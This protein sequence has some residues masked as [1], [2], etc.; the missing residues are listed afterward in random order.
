MP[1]V[2]QQITDLIGGTP[3]LA[4]NRLKE[5]EGLKADILAKLE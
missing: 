5:K 2:Y 3:L 4:L 1:Q